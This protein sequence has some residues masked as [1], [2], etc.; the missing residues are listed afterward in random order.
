MSERELPAGW[1]W[2]TVGELAEA[3][4]GKML[5]KAKN[6]AG[7]RLPYL[8][9]QN[10]RWECFDLSD[11]S[12]M[13]FKD[14]ELARFG[15]KP[16]DVLI[17]EGGEPG[18]AAIWRESESSIKFQK[19]L[20]RVRPYGALVPEWLIAHLKLDAASGAL[21]DHF[22][23]TTIKH[24]TGQALARYPVALPPLNEQKRIVAKLEAVQARAEGAKAALDAVGGL[25]EKFRQ[26]V[27]A[28]A[29]RGDLTREWRAQNPNTEPASALLARIR[30]ERRQRW[31][32]ANPKKKYVEPEPVDATNLPE[33][34]GG[35]V[36]PGSMKWE[37]LTWAGSAPP[38]ITTAHTCDRISESQTYLRI[39]ST[40]AM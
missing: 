10:V 34:P 39:A 21:G 9:N 12:E 3:N 17:C 1:A 28:A 8:R 35:G 33:L 22:T 11:T 27:L 13:F 14:D 5:D 18:R 38:A 23:G 6:T 15:L 29:F 31:A 24:F 2:A 7:Q 36:G 16:G 19:A 20:H 4:L 30:A 37:R 40:L 32:A 26:S 25:L